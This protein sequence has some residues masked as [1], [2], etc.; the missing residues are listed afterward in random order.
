MDEAYIK[1]KLDNTSLLFFNENFDK[2]KDEFC[3]KM[4]LRALFDLVID[5]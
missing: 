4:I 2:V 5:A 3:R 1:I